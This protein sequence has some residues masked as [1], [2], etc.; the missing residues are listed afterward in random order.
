M[1]SQLRTI[2][3]LIPGLV[4]LLLIS[5]STHS[6]D[7]APTLVG[8][9]QMNNSLANASGEGSMQVKI[10]GA[11]YGTFDVGDGEYPA[12]VLFTGLTDAPHQVVVT[13]VDGYAR[14]DGFRVLK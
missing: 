10:D 2:L 1:S 7:A 13:R 11:D 5:F 14:L 3:L 12:G 9:F 4:F 8:D 6:A